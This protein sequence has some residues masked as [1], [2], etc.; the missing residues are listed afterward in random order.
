MGEENVFR[1]KQASKNKEKKNELENQK[2]RLPLA[3]K[4]K[5]QS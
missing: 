3:H 1:E 5:R 2:T 4:E